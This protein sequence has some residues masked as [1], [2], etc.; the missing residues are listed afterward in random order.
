M[1]DSDLSYE[2]YQDPAL[3]RIAGRS[4]TDPVDRQRVKP[5]PR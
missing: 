4:F 5:L 1:T 3:S 2:G